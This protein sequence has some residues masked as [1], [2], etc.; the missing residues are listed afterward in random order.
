MEKWKEIIE[1]PGYLISNYGNIKSVDRTIQRID[2]KNVHYKGKYLKKQTNPNGYLFVNLNEH[3]KGHPVYI[4]KLVAKYFVKKPAMDKKLIVNHKDGNKE[5]NNYKNLEWVT[6]SYNS[7]HSYD[8]LKQ[9]K[10]HSKGF[11]KP[12]V[13]KQKNGYVYYDSITTASK[14]LNLSKTQI[15]RLLDT[16]KEDAEQNIYMSFNWNLVNKI[17]NKTDI[18]LRK[19]G[20]SKFILLI[21]N[22]EIVNVFASIK[23]LATYYKKSEYIIANYIKK[24]QSIEEN[25]YMK[26]ISVED[27]EMILNYIRVNSHAIDTHG[28]TGGT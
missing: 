19:K 14:K 27:I 15:F 25:I 21:K 7:K 10:P 11:P 9:S 12:I 8:V 22:D 23:E 26:F 20:L 2:G 16:E 5:N 6:Y 4:H 18:F 24:H 28:E 1:F 3:H 13:V 17:N